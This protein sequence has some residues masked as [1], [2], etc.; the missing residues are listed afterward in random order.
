MTVTD[1]PP[2]GGSVHRALFH[3]SDEEHPRALVPFLVDG[4]APGHPVAAA[5]SGA[6]PACRARPWATPR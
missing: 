1:L 3:A 6:G 5:V 4:L 2:R